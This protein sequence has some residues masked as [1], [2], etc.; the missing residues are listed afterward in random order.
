MHPLAAHEKGIAILERI[1]SDANFTR[2]MVRGQTIDEFGGRS[3]EDRAVRQ[4]WD[5]AADRLAD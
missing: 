3:A 4:I 1:L 2:A 5:Q